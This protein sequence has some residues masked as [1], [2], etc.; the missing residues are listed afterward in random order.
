MP[1]LRLPAEG[2]RLPEL[3][4]IGLDEHFYAQQARDADRAGDRHA[5]EAAKVGMYVTLAMDV[6]MP[7]EEKLRHFTHAMNR[8]CHPPAFADDRVWSFYRDL[9]HLAKEYCG[10]EAVRLASKEDDFYAARLAMGQSRDQIENDAEVFFDKLIG[11]G[12]HCP[13]YL[14][15]DD[16]QT[17]R[18]IRD[19]WI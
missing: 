7:W 11:R 2:P 9:S 14:L 15:E 3:P 4:G 16:Y 13:P 12:D 18:M 6:H 10:A 5:R 17:V 1:A 19:Q 8:H